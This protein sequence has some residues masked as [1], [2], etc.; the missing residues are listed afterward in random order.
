M[1][2]IIVGVDGSAHSRRALE[3]AVNEAAIRHAPLTVITVAQPALGHWGV[4]YYREYQRLVD[5]ARLVAEEAVNKTRAQL[6][7]KKPASITIQ[8]VSGIAAEEMIKA[9]R[10]ADMIVVGSRG[11]GGFARLLLGSV[12]TQI[13]HHANCP[14]VIIQ[15]EE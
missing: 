3:W 9:A 4:A 10:N 14:V 11:A 8:A 5:Q 2:G 13:M 7:D 1:T 15:S 12:S 6:S